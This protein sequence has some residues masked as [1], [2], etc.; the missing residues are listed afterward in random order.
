MW[1]LVFALLCALLL[2]RSF[3]GSL[4]INGVF[5][6]VTFLTLGRVRIHARTWRPGR[7]YIRLEVVK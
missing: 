4:R 3:E 5:F 6:G 2:S 1:T 7:V